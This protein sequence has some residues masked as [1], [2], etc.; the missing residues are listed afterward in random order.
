MEKNFVANDDIY[1]D[2]LD[3]FQEAG[4]ELREEIDRKFAEFRRK[5]D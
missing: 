4:N 1:D 5:S 2:L 3:V